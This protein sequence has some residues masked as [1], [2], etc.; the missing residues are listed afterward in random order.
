MDISAAAI[1]QSVLSACILGLMGFYGGHIVETVRHVHDDMDALKESQRNQLKT[2]IVK[3]CNEALA[4]GWIYATELETLLKRFE[5]YCRLGGNSY[6]AALI[7][8]VKKLPIRGELPE[9]H[10]EEVDEE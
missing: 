7:E 10:H 3:T 5:T 8:A 6:V 1:I 2:S 9:A 4:Q